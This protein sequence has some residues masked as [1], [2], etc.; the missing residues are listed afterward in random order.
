[1]SMRAIHA[2]TAGLL[3]VLA[4]CSA[5]SDTGGD[6][7][8]D[9]STGSTSQ[10]ESSPSESGPTYTAFD[11]FPGDEL[12]YVEQGV[13]PVGMRLKVVDTAWQTELAGHIAD[14]GAH[15]LV[16]YV[17]VTGEADDRGVGDAWLNYF[18]FQLSLPTVEG[19]CAPSSVDP[20]GVCVPNP[21][22]GLEPVADDEWRDYRWGS[23][24]VFGRV[25]LPAGATVI[26]ALAFEI[27][28]DAELPGDTG[29]CARSRDAY[30]EDNCVTIP[31][32]TE[33]RD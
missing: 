13:S 31:E 9:E 19:V 27:L 1:M 6:T 10:A 20:Y 21:I 30:P 23:A 25:D 7:G 8:G 3:L 17:A 18:D 24:D 12:L 4:G 14:P 2:L 22:T 32:P 29:F 26:G 28:E 15:Y 11:D 16:V 5:G 33:P